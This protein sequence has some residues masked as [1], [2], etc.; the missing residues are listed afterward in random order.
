L[1]SLLFS[2]FAYFGN[3]YHLFYSLPPD[4]KNLVH[5]QELD[6]SYNKLSI[7]PPELCELRNLEQLLLIGNT[8]NTLIITFEISS[9]CI[10]KKDVS[11]NKSYPF[12]PNIKQI[13]E[14]PKR[15]GYYSQ[16][17]DFGNKVI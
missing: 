9:L 1:K 13:E 7:I 11:I 4:I 3:P 12:G 15:S 2:H 6:L 8:G 16:L 5:L 17:I 10:P 14:F